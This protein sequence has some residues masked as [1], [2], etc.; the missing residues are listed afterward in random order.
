M[1]T[2]ERKIKKLILLGKKQGLKEKDIITP[3]GKFLAKIG[4]KIKPM[5]LWT[6]L[7]M[8]VVNFIILNLFVTSF[9]D[10]KISLLQL[11]LMFF[12]FTIVG[13]LCGQIAYYF[14]IRSKQKKLGIKW[15][16]L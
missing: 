7:E 16:D 14:T 8:L 13:T 9:N 1:S 15:D 12:P 11:L 3:I 4:I 10:G 6:P 5:V 2:Y